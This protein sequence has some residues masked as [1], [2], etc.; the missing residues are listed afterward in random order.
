MRVEWG[1]GRSARA[2][3]KQEEAW[4]VS[5]LHLGYYTA[6]GPTEIAN[7]GPPCLCLG[8]PGKLAFSLRIFP[9]RSE[10]HISNSVK[11]RDGTLLPKVGPIIGLSK[12]F[13]LI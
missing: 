13:N 6:P 3:D 7:F 5:W 2:T 4:A 12:G 11:G 10:N 8:E 9:L 1:G